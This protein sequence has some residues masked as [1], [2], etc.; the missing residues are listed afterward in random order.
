MEEIL[1]SIR[2][3]ISEDDA[4]E[5]AQATAEPEPEV[6]AEPEPEPFM[7]EPEPE[8]IEEAEEE[9]ILEL[10]EMAAAPAASLGDLDIYEAPKAVEPKPAPKPVPRV[11]AEPVAPKP[12]LVSDFTA[13]TAASAFGALNNALLMPKAGYTLEDFM[14]DMMRPML[15]SWL[16]ENLPSIVEEQV[17]QEVERISRQS[18]S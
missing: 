17:R 10:T 9:D 3:I 18:R 16:D 8:V 6:A 15:Q 11:V 5:E 14:K 2:R 7:A 13:S 4:P 12:A 1:A